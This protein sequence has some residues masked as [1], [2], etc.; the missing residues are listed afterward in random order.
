MEGY[1]EWNQS[2]R[3]DT[4]NWFKHTLLQKKRKKVKLR[5]WLNSNNL[6]IRTV[7]GF[8]QAAWACHAVEQQRWSWTKAE[9]LHLAA[10]RSVIEYNFTIQDKQF[11]QTPDFKSPAVVTYPV[12]RAYMES[13]LGWE[14]KLNLGLNKVST[15]SKILLGY[16]GGPKFQV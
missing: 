11:K 12:L 13:G 3:T 15:G 14:F 4:N 10:C 1:C 8:N 6:W 9:Y 16:R 2:L 5:G 7:V